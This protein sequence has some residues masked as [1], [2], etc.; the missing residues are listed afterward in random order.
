MTD[1]ES[2][3]QVQV[4]VRARIAGCEVSLTMTV[5]EAHTKD[6]LKQLIEGLSELG[7]EPIEPA[8]GA[9]RTGSTAESEGDDSDDPVSRVARE[10]ELD[11]GVARK[12]LGIKGDSVQLFRAGQYSLSDAICILCFT[13][14][15]GLGQ[16][17]MSYDAF[18]S[19]LSANQIKSKT[20]L[21]TLCFNLV[22][23][24][25]IDKRSYDNGRN[26]V[27]SSAGEQQAIDALKAAASG[28]RK[29]AKKRA[30]H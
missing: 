26:I 13:Y 6:K 7:V 25:R 21:S 10:A 28:E 27:L 9:D 11:T 29:T 19:L 4:S 17:S 12:L 2:A 14:E 1:E 5:P 3:T 30:K 20:P 24:G 23:D 15:K 18:S 8:R 16:Q 22:R